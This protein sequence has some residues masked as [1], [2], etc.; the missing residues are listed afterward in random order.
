MGLWGLGQ[1]ARRSEWM[2]EWMDGEGDVIITVFSRELGARRVSFVKEVILG[3][4]PRAMS[5]GHICLLHSA[6]LMQKG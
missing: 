2:D 4:E 6:I 3:L 1:G 5:Q